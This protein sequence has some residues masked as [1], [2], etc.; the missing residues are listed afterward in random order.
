LAPHLPFEANGYRH[1]PREVLFD[2][3]MINY[4]I[5]DTSGE[6]PDCSNRY[7]PDYHEKYHMTY[8]ILFDCV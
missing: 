5:C 2:E 6:D 3:K 8:F 7:F 1:Q 4:Q